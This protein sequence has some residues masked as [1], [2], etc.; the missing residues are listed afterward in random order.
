MIS[1][2]E[3]RV[4]RIKEVAQLIVDTMTAVQDHEVT[5]SDIS[6]FIE[7]QALKLQQLTK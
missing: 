4:Q 7:M 2:P 3:Q 5:L 1:T 6:R